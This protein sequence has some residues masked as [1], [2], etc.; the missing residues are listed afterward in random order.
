[1]I[2][3]YY[4]LFYSK[5]C[6]GNLVWGTTTQGNYNKL[7]TLQKR[8]LRCFERYIGNPR[9]LRTSPL[10]LKYNILRADQIFYFK[11]LQ[12][13]HREKSYINNSNNKPTYY[14]RDQKRHMPI[15]RTNYGKQSLTYQT[16]SLLNKFERDLDFDVTP[17]LFKK[18][19]KRVLINKAF[20]FRLSD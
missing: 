14:F 2:T 7:V 11:L 8:V 4:A 9:D 5:A 19:L 12:S 13:L 15:T 18:Q 10:F 1:M 6:Y 20:T 3:M 17:N 16:M